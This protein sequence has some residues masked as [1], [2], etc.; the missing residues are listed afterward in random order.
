M[1][2]SS[3]NAENILNVGV[4]LLARKGFEATSTREIVEAAGVT[5]PMLYYY[6]GNK[7]G[8]CKAAIRRLSQQYFAT[9]R[10]RSAQA[11]HPRQSL[12]EFVWAH[13]EFMR[14]HQDETL[15]YMSLFFGPERRKFVEDFEA[16]VTESRRLGG[17]ILASLI[18]AGMLRPACEEEFFR[19][20]HG[21]IDAWNRA[22][23]IEGIELTHD[24]AERI[25]QNL[26]GGFGTK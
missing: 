24:L 5:K 3:D 11:S 12:V 21:T 19:A 15:F 14:E 2:Q 17:E 22:S 16:I 1:A 4:H 23:A 26:L 13:F 10:A 20:L 8:L 9:L 18:A 7:E 6:F 25:V